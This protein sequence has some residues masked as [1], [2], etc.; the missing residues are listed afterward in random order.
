MTRPRSPISVPLAAVAEGERWTCRFCP[1]CERRRVMPAD[2]KTCLHCQMGATPKTFYLPNLR[3]VREQAGCT[4]EELEELVFMP[5]YQPRRIEEGKR[6]AKTKTARR[7]AGA[8]GTTVSALTSD[9]DE[10]AG[11]NPAFER[12]RELLL[13]CGSKFRMIGTGTNPDGIKTVTLEV[14]NGRPS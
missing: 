12:E 1:C 14:R 4:L 13:G 7:I 5:R 2:E 10:G 6:R 3:A 8:L 11:V 9:T